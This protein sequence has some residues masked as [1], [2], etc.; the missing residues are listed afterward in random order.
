MEKEKVYRFIEENEVRFIRLQFTDINGTMK[1]VEIPSDE[2]TSA[3]ET[4]IMF[5]GSSVEGF[6]RL[7]ESDMYL[8]P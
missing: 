8:K 2:I 6:A 4:G 7:H 1:N 5:D 3:L